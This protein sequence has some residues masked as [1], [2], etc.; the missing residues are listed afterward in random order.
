MVGRSNCAYY[1]GMDRYMFEE[2]GGVLGNFFCLQCLFSL[3]CAAMHD[4]YFFCKSGA[5]ISFFVL[6][7]Q[8]PLKNKMVRP[9]QTGYMS[10]FLYVRKLENPREAYHK[11]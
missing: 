8:P 9:R 4:F 1:L 11:L 6:A 7:H 5:R 10:S 3:R 2:G